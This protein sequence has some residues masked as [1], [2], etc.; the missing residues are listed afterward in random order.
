[1]NPAQTH[2]LKIEEWQTFRDIRL[3]ALADSPEAFSSTLEREQAYDE[4]GWRG[5]MQPSA[6]V[7]TIAIIDGQPVGVACG[8]VPE[9]RGGAVELYSMWVDPSARGAGVGALLIEDVVAWAT[10]EG[11]QTVELWVIDGNRQAERLYRRSGF[12]LTG[13]SQPHHNDEQLREHIMARKI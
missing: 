7:K 5:W 3:K 4:D 13:E 10:E 9:D 2:R 1:M 11:H 6:G 12:E 8:W